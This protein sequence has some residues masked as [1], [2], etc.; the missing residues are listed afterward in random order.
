MPV[1]N[2]E[3]MK[4]SLVAIAAIAVLVAG[5]QAR[6]WTS[7]DGSKTFDGTIRSVDSRNQTVT[8]L[9]SDGR[10]V[11]FSQDKL[12]E[13]DAEFIKEWES[14]KVQAAPAE[15]NTSSVIGAKVAKA[16][17]HQLDGKR[18]KRAEMTKSPEFYILY[19]SASW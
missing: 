7:S 17:L 16:K 3:S 1:Y 4:K 5:L 13:A 15:P 9:M 14:S 2:L 11:T 10:A 12:S 19:Y 6:T 8:V 18:M